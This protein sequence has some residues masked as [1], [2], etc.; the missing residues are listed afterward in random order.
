[1]LIF[2]D[3]RFVSLAIFRDFMKFNRFL[4]RF[5]NVLLLIDYS[6]KIEECCQNTCLSLNCVFIISLAVMVIFKFREF[7]ELILL[8][9]F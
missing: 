1:M 5:E 6:I 4:I 3:Y 9:Y 7:L 8:N 2:F